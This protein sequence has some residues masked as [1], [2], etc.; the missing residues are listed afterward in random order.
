MRKKERLDNLDSMKTLLI[1]FLL[2]L[3]IN[4]IA[5]P[6]IPDKFYSNKKNTILIDSLIEISGEN[7]NNDF[8]LAEKHIREA[9]IL[10][11]K[12]NDTTRII[13]C[14]NKL[15]YFLGIQN[16]QREALET[17]LHGIEFSRTHKDRER[18]LGNIGSCYYQI[19]DYKKAI[20]YTQKALQLA[21]KLND[22]KEI[23]RLK[24]N[25]G[26]FYSDTKEF[27]KALSQF[28]SSI[29]TNAQPIDSSL[30]LNAYINIGYAFYNSAR[31]DSAKKYFELHLE[32]SKKLD[33]KKELIL[34]YGNLA[35]F[36]LLKKDYTI[37][38]LYSDSAI[39]L[40]EKIN[41]LEKVN[42][43]YLVKSELEFGLNH[44]KSAY[45]YLAKSLEV[46]LKTK[47]S[48]PTILSENISLIEKNE[49]QIKVLDLQ[50]KNAILIKSESKFRFWL[51]ILLC[52][53]FIISFISFYRRSK[54]RLTIQKQENSLIN[55]QSKI[56]QLEIE[57]KNKEMVSNILQLQSVQEVLATIKQA[58]TNE[59]ETISYS[60]IKTLTSDIDNS[61]RTH[62]W[63]EFVVYFE[64][65]HVHFYRKL[66]QKVPTLSQ[67]ERKLCAFIKLNMT[68]KEISTITGQRVQTIEVARHRL[69]KKIGLNREENLATFIS[70]F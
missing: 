1:S 18:F 41:Y 35:S 14:S 12:I 20:Y 16:Q 44:F 6:Q 45:H 69:R 51:I 26:L 70:D 23:I 7:E 27:D 13:N 56:Y 11:I 28:Y 4:V 58:F 53:I 55:H 10:S 9:F 46:E 33:N 3:G 47:Q 19:P 49:A 50:N 62:L 68:S 40:S 59:Q 37:G 54:N 65:V 17:L 60:Q 38:T 25:L 57:Q 66:L 61:T 24:N 15:A 36:H 43:L 29:N 42:H 39:F 32:F 5:Q 67:N 21:E 2:C 34:A 8:F 64:K 31:L 22:K 30:F 52:L 63:E 48:Y